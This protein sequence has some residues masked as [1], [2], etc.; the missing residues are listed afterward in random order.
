MRIFKKT[1]DDG[2]LSEIE[3]F[4]ETVREARMPPQVEKSSSKNWKSLIEPA[5]QPRNT[6]LA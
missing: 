1:D 3:G 6:P 4:V 5:L 2:E